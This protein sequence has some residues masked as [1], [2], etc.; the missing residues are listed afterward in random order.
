MAIIDAQV[1][2]G[3]LTPLLAQLSLQ[4]HR[5]LSSHA[6]AEM[7][8]ENSPERKFVSTGY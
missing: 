7:R 5:L 8:G 6:S 4:S 3:F 2:P 1:F